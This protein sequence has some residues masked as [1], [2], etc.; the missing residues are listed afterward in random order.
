MAIT[1]ITLTGFVENG[2]LQLDLPEYV[3][4]G[5]VEVRIALKEQENQVEAGK[6]LGELL[7][8]GLVGSGADWEIGDSEEWVQQQRQKR[9]EERRKQWTDS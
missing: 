5:E 2:E 1:Y 3:V 6:T 7:E 9:R 8:S 4:D